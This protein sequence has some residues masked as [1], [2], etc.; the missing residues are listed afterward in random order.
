VLWG[1]VM[2]KRKASTAES[3]RR[4]SVE[5]AQTR[6]SRKETLEEASAIP[7]QEKLIEDIIG[8]LRRVVSTFREGNEP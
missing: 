1:A 8:L 3:D 2:S 4:S 5:H 7:D 6:N